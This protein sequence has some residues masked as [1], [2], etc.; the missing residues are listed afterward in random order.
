M[1]ALPSQEQYLEGERRP[2][3]SQDWPP[4]VWAGHRSSRLRLS[5]GRT[6]PEV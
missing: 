4:A 5:G 6:T 1:L 2:T 3:G